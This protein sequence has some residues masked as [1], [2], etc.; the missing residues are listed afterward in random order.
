MGLAVGVVVLA[1]V[2]SAVFILPKAVSEFYYNPNEAAG[3]Y[4]EMTTTR[5]NLDLSVYSELFLPGN[6]RDQVSAVSRGYGE[7][8]STDLQLDGKIYFCQWP[9][10]ERKTHSL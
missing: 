10:G 9:P 2:L 3:Q 8:D 1:V 6:H 4:E 7:Y 5:M